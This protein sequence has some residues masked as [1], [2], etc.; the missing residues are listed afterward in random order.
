M[1]WQTLKY[2][3]TAMIALATIRQPAVQQRY[4]D[5]QALALQG[6]AR[7]RAQLQA[8]HWTDFSLS[9]PAARVDDSVRGEAFE[10]QLETVTVPQE[11][12]STQLQYPNETLGESEPVE[13]LFLDT[14]DAPRQAE[15]TYAPEPKPM[16]SWWTLE[17]LRDALEPFTRIYLWL[18]QYTIFWMSAVYAVCIAW[19]I[20]AFY[21][22]LTSRWLRYALFCVL[23]FLWLGLLACK[24]AFWNTIAWTTRLRKTWEKPS[25]TV[26]ESARLRLRPDTVVPQSKR[27]TQERPRNELHA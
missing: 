23:G 5:L 15:P 16:P 10:S 7:T 11:D 9:T 6:A 17:R 2:T 22:V 19:I 14:V 3:I 8:G 1:L 4:K 24:H 12:G 13:P 27:G 25:R 18:S 26:T 21:R 20:C